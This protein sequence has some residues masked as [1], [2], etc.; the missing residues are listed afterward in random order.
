MCLFYEVALLIARRHDRRKAARD[1]EGIY[2][3]LDDDA[4]SP[5]DLD[6]GATS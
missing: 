1:N 4:T 6:V 2:R 3:D 5:L